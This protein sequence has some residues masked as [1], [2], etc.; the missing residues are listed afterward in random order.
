MG[1]GRVKKRIVSLVALLALFVCAA[2][3]AFATEPFSPKYISSYINFL[4][5]QNNSSDYWR[6]FVELAD[7]SYQYPNVRRPTATIAYPYFAISNPPL[8]VKGTGVF[9][10]NLNGAYYLK[11]NQFYCIRYGSSLQDSSGGGVTPS[12][13]PLLLLSDAYQSSIKVVESTMTSILFYTTEDLNLIGMRIYQQFTQGS[14]PC[15]RVIVSMF[16][17]ETLTGFVYDGTSDSILEAILAQTGDMHDQ[18]Q[19]EDEA[20]ASGVNPGQSGVNDEVQQGIGQLDDFDSEIF[21]NVADYT[22]QLDFGLDDWGEAAAGITYIGSIFLMIW[23]N[24]PTQVVVLSLMIGLCILLLGRGA[25][26]AGAVRRSHRDDDG[27][28]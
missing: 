26:V 17:I 27:G 8:S 2:V 28:G 3:P 12:I 24:S 16:S 4:A 10:N 25:R 5:F 18:W 7:G 20:Y 15:N 6:G 1:A 21:Q 11:A 22:S 19:K 13:N 23:N 14:L 9:F